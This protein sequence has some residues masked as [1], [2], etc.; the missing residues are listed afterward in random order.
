MPF[1]PFKI[2]K[3]YE[4]GPKFNDLYS[5]INLSKTK[6]GAYIVNLDQYES[7]TTH[8]IA[9]YEN[10]ENVTYFDSW[11]YPKKNKRVIGNENIITNIYRIKAC[12]WIMCRYF[13]IG[14]VD[15]MLK[16][17]ILLEYTNLFSPNEYKTNDKKNPYFIKCKMCKKVWSLEYHIFAVK[18]CFY[19]VFGASVEVKVIKYLKRKN[20]LKY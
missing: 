16:G 6:D 5:R 14:F 1:H 2:Q 17:K 11:T 13:C 4:N 12:Y 7:I 18:Y 3:Y 20:Q 9:L 19:L 15:F 10:A 8:W